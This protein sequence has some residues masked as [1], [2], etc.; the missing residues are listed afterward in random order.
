MRSNKS[1]RAAQ[2]AP[3]AKRL[4]PS[5][6]SVALELPVATLRGWLVFGVALV[7]ALF[8]SHLQTDPRAGGWLECHLRSPG[9]SEASSRADPV[10]NRCQVQPDCPAQRSTDLLPP[11]VGQG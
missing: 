1:K 6:S 11:T 8:P 7:G 3:A 2:A 10:P 5:R 4:P 9:T